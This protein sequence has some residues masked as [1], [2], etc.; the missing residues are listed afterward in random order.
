MKAAVERLAEAGEGHAQNR[1]KISPRKRAKPWLRDVMARNLTLELPDHQAEAV[2]SVSAV[3][4]T[5]PAEALARLATEAL[6]HERFPKVE[7]RDS[8]EGSRRTSW[9]PPSQCGKS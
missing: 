8:I 6:I 9:V 4:P 3:L 7:F 2:D 5:S 1:E